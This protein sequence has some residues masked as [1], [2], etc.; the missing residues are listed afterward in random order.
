MPINLPIGFTRRVHRNIQFASC[1][2]MADD[3]TPDHRF[4]WLTIPPA[5]IDCPVPRPGTY[6]F[7]SAGVQHQ[8]HQ[9]PLQFM[10]HRPRVSPA[11]SPEGS[12][13]SSSIDD[14]SQ[15]GSSRNR[16]PN[17]SDGETRFLLELWRQ[18]LNKQKKERC[19]LGLCRKETQWCFK[20]ARYFNLP[21]WRAV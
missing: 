14:M 2:K 1:F 16:C 3:F 15:P 10:P 13:E 20:R 8:F 12:S 21:H 19:G 6:L 11:L 7:Q 4:Y 9:S 18:F 17:W 5:E